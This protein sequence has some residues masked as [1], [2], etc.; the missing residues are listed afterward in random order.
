MQPHG[1]RYRCVDVDSS[2]HSQKTERPKTG[3]GDPSPHCDMLESIVEEIG[4][5]V[6][7]FVRPN[8]LSAPADLPPRQS[9]PEVSQHVNVSHVPGKRNQLMLKFLQLHVEESPINQLF[10]LRVFM[11]IRLPDGYCWSTVSEPYLQC[12]KTI[13]NLN[14]LTFI[15]NDFWRH[16]LHQH[17]TNISTR[18]RAFPSF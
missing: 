3:F 18:Y 6:P 5:V 1:H 17:C 10:A 12:G 8:S 14:N 7:P 15:V 4:R 16:L 2:S 13:I 11:P 9:E